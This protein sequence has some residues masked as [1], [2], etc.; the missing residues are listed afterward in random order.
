MRNNTFSIIIA[1]DSVLS[2]KK[3][4]ID[5]NKAYTFNK[6]QILF[7]KHDYLCYNN[8]AK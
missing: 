1:V 8:C 3:A 7:A 4:G 6:V 5:I 2:D